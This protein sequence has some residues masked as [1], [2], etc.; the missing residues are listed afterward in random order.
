MSSFVEWVRSK[1]PL[2]GEGGPRGGRAASARVLN[3]RPRGSRSRR[4]GGGGAAER[5]A[6]GAPS[7][8]DG[9]VLTTILRALGAFQILNNLCSTVQILY[10]KA[11]LHSL[12][13]PG[14]Y[15]MEALH[16]RI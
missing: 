14:H 12:I 10:I 9:V 8:R 3:P 13:V 4:G 6:A 15:S 11:F 2:R 1:K 5:G 7:P 16:A